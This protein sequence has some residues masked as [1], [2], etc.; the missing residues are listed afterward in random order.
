M[1]VILLEKIRNLGG[2]GDT[3]K[4]KSGYGRNFLIPE[5]KAVSATK[6]NKEVFETRRAELESKAQAVLEAAQKRAEELKEFK[7]TVEALASDEGKLYG[8]V[9]TVEIVKALQDQGHKI[10]KKEVIMP[11][12]AI[13]ECGEFEIGLQLHS[14]VSVDI[15]VDVVPAKA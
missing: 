15:I 1:E 5:G 4:V 12:G 8:S 14:D 10:E 7:L 2:L 3:V 13:H 11:E 6:A 9:S